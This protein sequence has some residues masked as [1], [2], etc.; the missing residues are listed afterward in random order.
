LA[1]YITNPDVEHILPSALDKGV[2]KMIA[3]A[4]KG[5]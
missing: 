4:V 2:A 5:V 3:E 1:E